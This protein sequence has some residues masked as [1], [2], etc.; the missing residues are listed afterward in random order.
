MLL[1]RG[2][3]YRRDPEGWWEEEEEQT[4]RGPGGWGHTHR[5]GWCRQQQGSVREGVELC[6]SARICT[7]LLM[8][9][10]LIPTTV[11]RHMLLWGRS[12]YSFS[13]VRKPRL[14]EVKALGQIIWLR[15]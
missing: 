12:C 7:R 2:R 5:T 11:L 8:A 4:G 3:L 6:G 1:A 10:C 15:I 9:S 14:R 13:L